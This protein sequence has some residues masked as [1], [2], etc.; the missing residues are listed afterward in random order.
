[1]LLAGHHQRRGN[2]YS[3]LVS[4]SCVFV[5]AGGS[6]KSSQVP[7]ELLHLR[8]QL[9]RDRVQADRPEDI[10]HHHSE[11]M[12][13][14]VVK[15]EGMHFGADILPVDK[16]A[17]PLI[18]LIELR[19]LQVFTNMGEVDPAFARDHGNQP[20][21]FVALFEPPDCFL[22]LSVPCAAKCIHSFEFCLPQRPI[23]AGE[24]ADHP[25]EKPVFQKAGALFLLQHLPVDTALHQSPR[26]RRCGKQ[27]PAH[28]HVEELVDQ[29]A[30]VKT[31]LEQIVL[32][33]IGLW[34]QQRILCV[35]LLVA[36]QK[37]RDLFEIGVY[38]RLGLIFG[39]AEILHIQVV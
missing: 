22:R 7:F 27:I 16:R 35:Q 34:G 3:R 5:P 11:Q 17:G 25:A 20:L 23:L 32:R 39:V 13:G 36:I 6:P 18:R 9:L 19:F 29:L 14:G 15:C 26:H 33:V 30:H 31:P 1:M 4:L 2:L 21:V 37:I 38:S 12:I 8:L 28:K 10:R 24:A